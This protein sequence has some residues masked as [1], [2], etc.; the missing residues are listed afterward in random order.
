MIR[1][2]RT[3]LSAAALLVLTGCV[4]GPFAHVNPHDAATPLTLSIRGG[5]DTLRVAGDF[6]LFQAVTDPVTNGVTVFWESGDVARL[7]SQGSGLF[8]VGVLPL[9]PRTVEVRAQLGAATATRNVVI[10][11]AVAP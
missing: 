2:L 9:T 10:M 6:V 8:Q 5:A 4:D 3:G 1:S 11:P 7:T